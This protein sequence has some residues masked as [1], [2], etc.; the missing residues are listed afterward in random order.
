[1]LLYNITYNVLLCIYSIFAASIVTWWNDDYSA[2]FGQI[3]VPSVGVVLMQQCCGQS[4]CSQQNI[5]NKVWNIH[6]Q[7]WTYFDQIID[8]PTFKT[9]D[10]QTG[11]HLIFFAPSP[12]F[13]REVLKEQ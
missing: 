3:G 5:I 10:L 11:W 7:D 6:F 13:L 9:K 12:T 1:M 4:A 2:S 8:E